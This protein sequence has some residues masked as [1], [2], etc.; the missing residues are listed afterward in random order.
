MSHR[1]W[2]ARG[3]FGALLLASGLTVG[4]TSGSVP[5]T[6]PSSANLT[7][8]GSFV[9]PTGGSADRSSGA[10][11]STSISEGSSA[12]PSTRPTSTPLITR[13]SH[14]GRPTTATTSSSSGQ[15]GTV[16]S[17]TKATPTVQTSGLSAQEI[18]DRTAI[19]Q[20]WVNFWEVYSKINETPAS[21]RESV[22]MPLVVEPLRSKI[23]KAAAVY[24]AK[25]FGD[26]GF[27]SHRFYW[28]P[29]VEGRSPAI[30]GDC[31]DTSKYGSI[32]TKTGKKRTKGF[33]RDNT[34][35]VF[36]RGAD[37]VWRLQTIESLVNQ[38]C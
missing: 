29:P 23:I 19:Q 17:T 36:V 12:P 28:G 9:E 35:A 15:G 14:S 1:L 34:R 16:G 33:E 30:M 10:T 11:A 3:L 31:M 20:A 21:Q 25:G 7:P 22:L 5:V 32:V 13:S 26:Y 8:G 18:A 38:A 4:C 24:D 2:K 27:V 6:P 37:Q